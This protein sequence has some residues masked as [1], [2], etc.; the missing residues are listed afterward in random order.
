MADDLD[1]G[2][3]QS[4]GTRRGLSICG[5]ASR[6][7]CSSTTLQS[8]VSDHQSKLFK[9][10]P[11]RSFAIRLTQTTQLFDF[12]INSSRSAPIRAAPFFRTSFAAT[13]CCSTKNSIW[14]A[15]SCSRVGSARGKAKNEP[16]RNWIYL[17]HLHLEVSVNRRR[18]P[19]KYSSRIGKGWLMSAFL[20]ITDS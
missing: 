1:D 5:G 13:R 7:T 9:Q 11:P 3:Y 15:P 16:F 10:M 8:G 14:S 12:L 2:L 6:R 17:S 18:R 19:E 4:S 20:R